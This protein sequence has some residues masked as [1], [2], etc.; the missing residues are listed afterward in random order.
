MTDPRLKQRPLV[1]PSIVEIPIVHDDGEIFLKVIHATTC[2]LILK[3]V[4]S[5][6]KETNVTDLDYDEARGLAWAL[7]AL[8]DAHEEAGRLA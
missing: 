1:P 8:C 6:G 3:K 4:S 5:D 2:Y 7:N